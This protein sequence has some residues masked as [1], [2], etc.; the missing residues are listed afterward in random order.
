MYTTAQLGIQKIEITSAR[1]EYNLHL[2]LANGLPSEFETRPYEPG[3][4]EYEL[5]ISGVKQVPIPQVWDR[6]EYKSG[7][8]NLWY[9]Q[10]ADLFWQFM[11]APKEAPRRSGIGV[12]ALGALVKDRETGAV[13]TVSGGWSSRTGVVN[14]ILNKELMDVVI[15]GSTDDMCGLSGLHVEKA[16]VEKILKA[17]HKDEQYFVRPTPAYCFPLK[18]DR[19]TSMSFIDELHPNHS[20]AT[21][22]LHFGI[23]KRRK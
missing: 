3:D 1:H 16:D 22:E 8:G 5:G 4:F 7:D 13:F 20:S 14:L 18:E 23:G 17:F 12:G 9:R 21:K 11:S 19:F 15:H 2:Y 6:H 10:R